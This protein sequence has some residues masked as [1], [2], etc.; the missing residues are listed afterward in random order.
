MQQ[1]E[2]EG[3]ALYTRTMT[4]LFEDDPAPL[5]ALRWKELYNNLEEALD[6]CARTADMIEAVSLK[7][8]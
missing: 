8:I 5:E 2:E 4:D 7:R 6:T 1:L 3:D